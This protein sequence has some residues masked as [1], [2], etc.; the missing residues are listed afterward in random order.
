M[1]NVPV[2]VDD[3][4]QV[5]RR[6]TPARIG[7]GRAGGSLP[8]APMLEF[9]L[10]HAQARDAVHLPLEADG[11]AH[12][13]REDGHVVVVA[14]SAAATREV[15]L[16]RPDL[17]RR[18]DDDSRQCLR[19]LAGEAFDA[20]FVVGDGLSPLA[21]HRH[22]RPVLTLAAEALRAR[23][24]RVGPVVV[25]HQARVALADEAGEVLGARQVAI[26]LGERPGLSSPDSLG[27]YLTHR[28]RSGCTDAQRNCISNVRP[29]GLSYVRAAHTLVWLMLEAARRGGTGIAL[30]DD[31][32][33][34]A[35]LVDERS[36]AWVTLSGVVDQA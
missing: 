32:A 23:G 3:P 27:I 26:L 28:P 13:L 16:R 1:T 18:L 29:E 19:L 17:G 11:L 4:W 15:Y 2:L 24:W 36:R 10:A 34:V 6:V 35:P 8:T 33:A 7:L 14:R 12:A 25:V 21:V 31:S 20:V 22:A 5:L 9:Q 30:K